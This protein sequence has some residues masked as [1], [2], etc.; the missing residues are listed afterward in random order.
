MKTIHYGIDPEPFDQVSSDEIA[1]SRRDWGAGPETLVIGFVGRLVSQKSIDVLIRAFAQ[2]LRET[3]CNARLVIVGDGPLRAELRACAEREGVA[4]HVIW[5]GFREDIAA[6][7]GAF[8]VFALT[9]SFEGFGLVLIEAM[10]AGAPIVATCVSA[11]PEVVVD[12][13]TGLLAA[14]GAIDQVARAFTLLRDPALRRRLGRAG[15]E[16]VRRRFTLEQ[17]WQATDEVYEDALHSAAA[18]H[19]TPAALAHAPG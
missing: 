10:A 4:D 11:I 17:M 15:Y 18:Q 5:P 2:F 1:Q 13:E 14:P 3:N 7:M 16:R 8:D 19:F 9:S 6:V 12:G